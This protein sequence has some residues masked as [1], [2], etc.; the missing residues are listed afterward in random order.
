MCSKC[1]CVCVYLRAV[2]GTDGR[3]HRPVCELLDWVNQTIL[4]GREKE[5]NTGRQPKK[6]EAFKGRELKLM[7]QCCSSAHLAYIL[8]QSKCEEV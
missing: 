8:S 4:W 1:V 6:E 2:P 5:G 7:R 3:F